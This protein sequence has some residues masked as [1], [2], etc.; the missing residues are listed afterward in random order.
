MNAVRRHGSVR[1]SGLAFQG[2]RG[3]PVW[4]NQRKQLTGSDN[5]AGDAMTGRCRGAAGRVSACLEE[6]LGGFRGILQ[7]DCYSAYG[8][9]AA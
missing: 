7:C 4:E 3:A 6:L 2:G 8:T 5:T 9:H 1:F